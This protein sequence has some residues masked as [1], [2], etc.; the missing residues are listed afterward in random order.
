M[1]RATLIA[2]IVAGVAATLIDNAAAALLFGAD[3]V[4]LT[5][6][7]PGRFLVA[8]GG[9]A[10]LP[11]LLGLLEGPARYVLAFAALALGAAV[12]AK[13]VFG[14]A[15]PWPNVLLLTSVYAVSAILI[16][17][18]MMRRSSRSA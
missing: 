3:F 2:V 10:L 16:Y 15:A 8:L 7:R 6:E 4:A 1:N 11:F 18:A 14:Y 9:A 13:T 17:E 5:V 12:L